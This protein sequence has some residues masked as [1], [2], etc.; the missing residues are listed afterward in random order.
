MVNNKI[1][2][3][4]VTNLLL[5]MVIATIEANNNAYFIN[6]TGLPDNKLEFILS[7][8]SRRGG[9]SPE[10]LPFQKTIDLK[11]KRIS[12]EHKSTD[13]FF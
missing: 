1:K 2:I 3:T 6:N 7:R 5:F 10:T 11:N 12:K 8:H 4:L 9:I 13:W